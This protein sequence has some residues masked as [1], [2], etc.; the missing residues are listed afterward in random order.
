MKRR[1][2]FVT[3]AG[4]GIVSQLN[5]QHTIASA[6][7]KTTSKKTQIMGKPANII[8]SKLRGRN[9]N[10][11]TVVCR[12]GVCATSQ[13]VASTVGTDILKSG[14]NAVD[15]AVAMSAIM[16]VVE[17]MSCGPGGDLFAIVWI[18]KDKKLYGLN[19]SG[20]SPY[21]WNR[22]EAKKRGYEDEL[23]LH[24]P[25]TW[26]VPGC[27]SGW[28]ALQQRLGKLTFKES[29]APAS[30]YAR[31]GYI[32]SEIIARGFSGADEAFKIFPNAAK[33]YLVDGKPPQYGQVVTNPD[34][35]HFFEI[36]RRDGA[37]AFYQGEIAE[38][39]VQYS[40]ERGGVFTLEDFID[41][42][43]TW[44]EP[45]TATYRGYNVWEIPPNGQ[46]IAALQILNMLEQFDIASLEPNC[47]EHLHLFIEAKK[48]AFEDRAF[49]YGDMDFANVPLEQLISKEYGKERAKLIDPKRAATDVHPGQLDG[50]RDTIYLCTADEEGNMVSLIQSIYWGW[51]S[52]EVPTGLGF[53]LQNRG[54]SFN[55]DPKH[56]NTLEP[57]KRPFHTIIP[58]FLTLN[59]QP[60]CAFGVMGGDMQPQGHSQV[61]MNMIDYHMSPQQAGEQPRVQHFGSS[62]PWGGT[63]T[64]GG[65]VGIE[66]G[67]DEKVIDQ[68]KEMGHTISEV[69][70]GQYGGYQAI[71]REDEPMRYFAGS[72]PRKDGS[73]V[74]Y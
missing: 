30:E 38:R 56:P 9:S 68:L 50:S 4:L 59:G 39:I 35:S 43:A 74:G 19:A 12:N 64:A 8:Q 10:R 24:G 15:A 73:A 2:F 72:E 14:G 55:L 67:I 26:S 63:M 42:T 47:A 65:S 41:H 48:L 25:L 28:D 54:R 62:N 32:L 37:E 5:M 11:S 27:V 71:W 21:A 61:L 52:R 18:E 17:P 45:V 22:D 1:D 36:L 40:K 23:P 7:P 6:A 13:S 51:G 20:R 34:I 46:G 66:A 57:H 44:V 16:S 58:G 69:G 60:K 29:L 33:T 70:T 3:G 53:C 49:Y 31:E